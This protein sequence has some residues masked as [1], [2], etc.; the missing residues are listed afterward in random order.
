MP[1]LAGSNRPVHQPSLDG[2]SRFQS[3]TVRR[4]AIFHSP[5]A[6]LEAVDEPAARERVRGLAVRRKPGE[7]PEV[8]F[9]PRHVAVEFDVA[10]AEQMLHRTHEPDAR[11]RA[12]HV[13]EGIARVVAAVL[14]DRVRVVAGLQQ[15]GV[16]AIHAARIT[17]EHFPDLVPGEHALESK[18]QGIG[19]AG[20][21]THGVVSPA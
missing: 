13:V 12:V 11:H 8:G 15:V 18:L 9:D 21:G 7:R 14:L 5:V 3:N 1:G 16:G 17:R 6:S 2:V 4:C 10:G 20:D 19:R